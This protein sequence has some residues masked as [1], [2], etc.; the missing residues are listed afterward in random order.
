VY[1][2]AAT[3]QQSPLLLMKGDDN[4]LFFL[5]QKREP[6]VGHSEFSYTLNRAMPK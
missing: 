3:P 6:L 5:S 2:L 1:Q 4:V